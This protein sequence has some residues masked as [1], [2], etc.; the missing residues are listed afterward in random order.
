[1]MPRWWLAADYDA[2]VTD[3]AGLAWE[4]PRAGV[5]AMTEDEV[6]NASGQRQ[7]TGQ[8]SP[9]AKKWAD[10][11]TAHYDELSTADPIFGQLRNCMDLAVVAALI[12]QH[13]LTEKCGWDMPLLLN[14]DLK[15]QRFNA[16]HT[17][18]TAA[19]VVQKRTGL[20]IS[21]SGGVQ[22]NPWPLLESPARTPSW[23]IRA[24]NRPL[25]ATVG[26]G[27]SAGRVSAR[28][29]DRSSSRPARSPTPPRPSAP[30]CD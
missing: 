29:R 7:R 4:L 19:S 8:S 16:P 30:R 2:L 6:L 24:R 25:P 9:L 28:T 21:A 12:S 10:N 14:P 23:A 22:I 27:T 15:A 17:V 3:G 1:M 11:M 13:K 5:K 20:V 18:D 26:G